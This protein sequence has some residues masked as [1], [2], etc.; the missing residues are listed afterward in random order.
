MK[1]FPYLGEASRRSLGADLGRKR[2]NR[3]AGKCNRDSG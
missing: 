3:L 2:A 1:R